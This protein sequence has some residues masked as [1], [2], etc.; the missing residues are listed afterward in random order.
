MGYDFF[1]CG[2]CS[3]IYLV[4][5]S[6]FNTMIKN[7]LAC[8]FVFSFS[9]Y[10]QELQN[11]TSKQK[12][13]QVF[14]TAENTDLRLTL[15]KNLNF[16]SS[17]QPVESEI[18]IFVNPTQSFQNFMGIG[19]AITDA[20]AE[21]FA[22]LS[23]EKQEEL[24][25]AYYDTKNGIGYS[26]LRTSIHSS[27]FASESY[28]YIEEGDQELKTFSIDH[29]KTYRIPMIKRAIHTA[30]GKLL[31]YASPW[32]P[33]SF[34]K[35]NGTML[36]GGTLLP[37][38]YQAWANYY[39]KFVKAYEKEGM[40]IWG[41]TIQNEP[42]ATQKW[43]SCLFTADAERNFLK[44]YLG[45]TM[46]KQGLG[47]KKIV[48][49]DH[50]RDLMNQRANAIFDDPEASKYAWGMGFH[51]YE[52][53]AGGQPM[54]DNV[55]KVYEAYPSKN[56]LFTEGCV[57]RFDSKKYQF[58][59]NAERY[60]SAMIND[61]N[62]GTVGWTDWNILLDEKGGPNHKD[63]FCFAPI[64]ADM[65]TGELIYTPSYYYIGHFSKFIRPDAKRISTAS[66][67]SNLLSTTFKN[68]DDSLVTVVMNS[69][70]EAIKYNLIVDKEK[71][72]VEIP[73]HAIQTLV[74]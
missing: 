27:D 41:I 13:I 48:V 51:W 74:Y 71:T 5:N 4:S 28:T 15:A 30:G 32:S 43:E 1:R 19:G 69:S 50:N 12:S 68:P 14:T 54:F 24:L 29:D 31:L 16:T 39:A 20:S 37:E 8:I 47:T 21:V 56:L 22:R 73:A 61:F 34:M 53:W 33:P 11:L 18:S 36:K 7:I 57:E 38:F 55:R 9:T 72:I 3:N 49:W 70:E 46:E 23:P 25:T 58:W 62:N 52:T 10:A 42:M 67:R 65:N 35:S 26:L 59:G 17:Q 44:N 66:S 6:I 40:P 60:G 64:H 45:P 2:C 63:N